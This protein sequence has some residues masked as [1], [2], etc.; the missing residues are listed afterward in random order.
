[1]NKIYLVT[2]IQYEE[3]WNV[4]FF[5][6]EIEAAGF[7]EKC[8]RYENSC[9]SWKHRKSDDEHNLNLKEWESAHPARMRIDDPNDLS[10][11]VVDHYRNLP[12]VT[13]DS[14]G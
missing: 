5:E 13:P 10:I 2:Y 1:M 9:P 7:I 6:T 14:V 11:V 8:K 4:C 12:L 3:R